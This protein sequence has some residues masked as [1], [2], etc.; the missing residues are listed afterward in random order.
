MYRTSEEWVQAYKDRNAYWVHD[1]NPRRPHALLRSGLHSSGFFNSRLVIAD[2]QLLREAA[3]NL[4][5]LYFQKIDK[6]LSR[7][8]CVV[9][10]QT[11]A[12]KLARFISEDIEERIDTV[13][14]WASPEKSEEGGRKVM[15]FTNEGNPPYALDRVLLCEDVLT[16]GGSV[17]LCSEA[18]NKRQA[19]VLHVVL[20][21]V[22]RSGL[23]DLPGKQIVSL[24]EKHM[25]TWPAEE[26]P[27]CKQGSAAIYP[28]D[29]WDSLNA[30][31]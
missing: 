8:D 28:K 12:T 15:K 25:P 18:I 17:E 19:R 7:I 23:K 6:D 3:H 13:C 2:E 5:Q 24:V 22:N 4:V 10:P 14:E 1:G 20:V 26:C 27:L 21:L 30:S 16:T 29:N 31:Y 11:G 9:G